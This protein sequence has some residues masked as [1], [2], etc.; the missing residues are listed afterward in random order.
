MKKYTLKEK[1]MSVGPGM[2]I[3]G[4]F[5]GPGTVTSA[6]RAGANYGYSL[7]WCVIFSVIAVIVLQGMASRLG[8]ITQEGLA[9]NLVNDF[10]Q[11]P[12]LQK[13]LCWL[14]AISIAIGG[15]AYMAGDLTGTSIGISALTGISPRIIAP[16]WGV[17]ILL[18]VTFAREAVKFLEKLLGVCVSIMA[19]VFVITMVV[20]KPDLTKVFAGIIPTIPSGGALYCVS[21]IGTT[22]VPYN[23]YLHAASSANRFA[24]SR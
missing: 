3:V 10:K 8:I 7:F 22:V 4:S 13:T 20:V 16:L 17:C 15:F 11:H 9:E 14:V 5:I 2:L 6:T 12:A 24:F 18:I 19:V 21:L 1:L 23:L